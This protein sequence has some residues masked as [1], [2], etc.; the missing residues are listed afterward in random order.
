MFLFVVIFAIAIVI[1]VLFLLRIVLR[2]RRFLR[3]FLFCRRDLFF[4]DRSIDEDGQNRRDNDDHSGRKTVLRGGLRSRGLPCGLF[5][6]GGENG[7]P[8]EDRFAV[9]FLPETPLHGVEEAFHCGIVPFIGQSGTDFDPYPAVFDGDEQQKPS[10]RLRLFA[11][12]AIHDRG[13]ERFDRH[14]L[15]APDRHYHCSA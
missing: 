12:P 7:Q 5:R 2:I 10:V 6:R 9:F 8:G 15:Q 11:G 1:F 14:S 3:V 4:A 13:A